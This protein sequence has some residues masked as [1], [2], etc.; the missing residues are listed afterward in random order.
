M[1]NRFGY[2]VRTLDFVST[3]G[4]VWSFSPRTCDRPNECNIHPFRDVYYPASNY[5]NDGTKTY[6]TLA[7]Q[8]GANTATWFGI[9]L[10]NR[11]LLP[12]NIAN[13]GVVNAFGNA[14]RLEIG[15]TWK[16]SDWANHFVSVPV[17][18]V[19]ESGAPE[20]LRTCR[21]AA[22]EYIELEY[23]NVGGTSCA[24]LQCRYVY[25]TAGWESCLVG[26][27]TISLAGG[28]SKTIA[29]LQ[30]GDLVQGSE[31]S[32]K[33]T[34][35]NAYQS[36]LRVLYGINGG[37]AMITGNHPIRTS[38]GWKLI[39]AKAAA[40]YA[41]KPGYSKTALAIGDTIVTEKGPVTVK[42]IDRHP[43]IEPVTTYNIKLENDASFFANGVE[44]KSF[45]EMQMHYR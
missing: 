37:E 25:D 3:F 38:D 34:A 20:F 1:P 2:S 17:S 19:I 39:E 5:V 27:T 32:H 10:A 4:W 41:V 16:A 24:Y 42:S 8:I 9:T 43:A 15:N 28:K 35:I 33:I 45:D 29:E 30:I 26:K 40:E 23:L 14:A 36:A 13:S 21:A 7:A 6:N 12:N 11:D 18:P 22:G 44:V 31:G